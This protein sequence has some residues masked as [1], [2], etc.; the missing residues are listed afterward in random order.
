MVMRI[1]SMEPIPAEQRDNRFNYW[2]PCVVYDSASVSDDAVVEVMEKF[3]N[4][5][6][7]ARPRIP[8]YAVQHRLLKKHVRRIAKEIY[9]ATGHH[10]SVTVKL[11]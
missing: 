3:A 7:R 11:I 10:A 4:T 8:Q 1:C 5:I 9:K 6:T 2:G